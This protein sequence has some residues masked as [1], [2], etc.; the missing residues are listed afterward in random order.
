VKQQIRLLRPHLN[1]YHLDKNLLFQFILSEFLLIH[2]EISLINKLVQDENSSY[3]SY[4]DPIHQLAGFSQT[5]MRL[6]AW[7]S[8]DGMLAK[9]LIY[10]NLFA[11]H[12]LSEKESSLLIS[13]ANQAWLLCLTCL[14]INRQFKED[15]GHLLFPGL[16]KK[17]A[18]RLIQSFKRIKKLLLGVLEQFPVNENILFFILRHDKQLGEVYGR[19]F[20]Y[21]LFH[22]LFSGGLSEATQFLKERY[23]GRGF[24]DLLP[25]IST[26]MALLAG[27]K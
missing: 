11:Q 6:F 24:T 22:K 2:V 23:S 14:D 12:Q 9:F 4:Q 17:A 1:A 20:V 8:E 19:F 21:K 27:E 18:Q 26:K 13:T 15:P 7:H 16:M 25:V 10:S 5:Y 3:Q